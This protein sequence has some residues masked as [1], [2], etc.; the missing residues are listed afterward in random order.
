MQLRGRARIVAKFLVAGF[1][2]VVANRIA[3]AFELRLLFNISALAAG[4]LT[5]WLG[6][7]FLLSSLQKTRYS[8]EEDSSELGGCAPII[9]IWF[10]LVGAVT[11]ERVIWSILKSP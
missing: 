6:G 11:I 9:G 1:L 8:D 2:V 3:W 7:V 5:L 4:A 10:L